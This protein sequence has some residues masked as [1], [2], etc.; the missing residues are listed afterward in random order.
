MALLLV[1]PLDETPWP[2]L[3]P[4]VADL[5][6]DYATFGPGPLKGQPAVLSDEKRAILYRLYEVNPPD[7]HLPGR[8]RFKRGAV[9]VRKGLAKTEFGAWVVFAELHPEGPVRCDGFDAHGQPVGR[10]VSDPYIPMLANTIEQSEELAYGALKFICEEGPDAAF[11]DCSDERV[12]RLD[13]R[14]RPDG[15]A[16]PLS[17]S[18]NARDGARTTFQLFDEP[19]RLYL[20]RAKDAHSTMDANLPKRPYDDPWSLYIGTAGEPG[21]NSVQ[22]DLHKDAEAIRDGKRAEP[23]LFYFYRYAGATLDLEDKAQRIEAIAEATGPEG[24]YGPGQFEDIAEKWDREGV[25][26]GY[27]ERVWLNRWTKS[28]QQAFDVNRWAELK[29]IDG[30]V[31]NGLR[32]RIPKRAAVTAGFD[33]ARRKDSTAIVITELATGTQE[34]YRLWERPEDMPDDELWEVPEEQV[35]LAV[36]E[37]FRTYNVVLF[38]GDPPYWSS[39]M[40]AWAGK[41]KGRV[42]EW[43]T[44]RELETAWATHAYATAM[45]TGVVG[46]CAADPLASS[47]ARHLGNAGRENTKR[48]VDEADENSPLLFVLRK[49]HPTRKFDATMAAVLSWQ[50]YLKAVK[51]GHNVNRGRVR[52]LRDTSATRR[53]PEGGGFG[54]RR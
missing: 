25:D 9:S 10:P 50:A 3:G 33:G 28:D 48:R 1:P 39:E 37:L 14:G 7:H 21:Q 24:E 16:L 27:L 43:W 19:H 5:I 26:K 15:K 2:T 36:D 30:L 32:R 11:F 42:E 46:W 34:L 31:T 17:N 8:R 29:H 41:H 53:V 13:D 20:P 6:E 54:Y 51:K 44:N 45:A 35:N 52:V 47:L 22:E 49:I 12:M 18:P 23:R 40:G 38:F 4:Q